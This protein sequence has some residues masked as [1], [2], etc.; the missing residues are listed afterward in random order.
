MTTKASARPQ[1]LV[2]DQDVASSIQGIPSK[3]CLNSRG[4]SD[5]ELSSCRASGEKK[6]H[7]CDLAAPN[8]NDF[9]AVVAQTTNMHS[10][11]PLVKGSRQLQLPSFRSL[12]ISSCIPN[13]LLTPPDEATIHDTMANASPTSFPSSFRRSSYPEINVPKT[14][15]PDRSD[16]TSMLGHAATASETPTTTAPSHPD[17]PVLGSQVGN[18][19]RGTDPS[20]SD[21]EG[22]D[23]GP[24]Q[25]D[26][27]KEAADA[28]GELRGTIAKH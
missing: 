12:G 4:Y 3:A 1:P 27:L 13:A 19:D 11:A 15:S 23:A 9:A 18:V 28:L 25:F 21:S 2:P 6:R 16:Y 26:W 10:I 7:I 20:R 17:L 8:Q 14:P 22:S 5:S 24:G